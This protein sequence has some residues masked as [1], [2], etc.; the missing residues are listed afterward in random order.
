MSGA[1]RAAQAMEEERLDALWVSGAVDDVYG[2]HSQN[3]FYV[4]GFTGSAGAALIARERAI[5]VV[6]SRYTEQ[7]G[8]ECPGFEVFDA[9]RWKES[10]LP[11]PVRRAGLAGGRIGVSAA[12]M[13]A[14]AFERFQRAL[15]EIAWGLRPSAGLA[16]PL[17]EKLRAQK[18]ATDI[19]ALQHAIDL[20][21]QAFERVEQTLA[22]GMRDRDRGGDRAHD[23]G[24]WW[25]GGVVR[26]DRGGWRVGGAAAC[27]PATEP[28][29]ED[30][31]IVIDMGAL[32]GGYCS[33]LTRTTRVGRL[34]PEMRAI[35]EVVFEAQ[36][37]AIAGVEAGMPGSVAH[38]LAEDVIA[39][40]GHGEHFGHGLGHGVGLEVHERPYLGG[41]SEDTLEEGMV[42]TI[43]PHIASLEASASRTLSCWRTGMPACSATPTNCLLQECDR[44]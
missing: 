9:G 2:R 27:E 14:G 32:A 15:G 37:A 34:S 11:E 39:K 28:I 22:A 21:D 17:V 23:P 44:T 20:A 30:E 6:D 8:R 1:R 13:T 40:A 35:Y 36:Q 25:A 41:G 18:D 5:M 12:D 31:P 7:A 3:R 29:R 33:D 19:A 42:F 16:S 43:E 38:R 26:H 24:A 4:S 10:W